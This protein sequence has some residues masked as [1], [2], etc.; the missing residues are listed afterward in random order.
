MC[1]HTLT[2]QKRK[3]EKIRTTH[4]HVPPTLKNTYHTHVRHTQGGML[5]L[6]TPDR[7]NLG[8]SIVSPSPDVQQLEQLARDN[9]VLTA[10]KQLRLA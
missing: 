6:E 10:A 2:R 1:H 4:T 7:R 5:A 9:D 3:E 8:L